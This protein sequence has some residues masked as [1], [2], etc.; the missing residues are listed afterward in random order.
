MGRLLVDKDGKRKIEGNP[1]G[2]GT[3]M[4]KDLEALV[5]K[6]MKNGVFHRGEIVLEAI[7]NVVKF[8]EKCGFQTKGQPNGGLQLMIK[9]IS[10]GKCVF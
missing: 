2:C 8:Y 5:L 4:M 3:A 10:P 9:E 1:E 7:E 6:T